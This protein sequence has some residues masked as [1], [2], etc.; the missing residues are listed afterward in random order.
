VA[1]DTPEQWKRLKSLA[2][3]ADALDD[4]HQAWLKN[5]S[6]HVRRLKQQGFEVVK[7]PIDVEEW[8]AWCQKNG[9]ALDGAARSEFTSRKVSGKFD[10]GWLTRGQ[11]LRE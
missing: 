9:K 3:D 4:T 10:R 5:A 11:G 2:A 8:V 6:G 1:W 7:V